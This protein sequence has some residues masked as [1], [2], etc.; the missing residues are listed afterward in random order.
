MVTLANRVKM[1][2]SGTPS[3]GTITLG[4]AETGY[5]TFAAGGVSDGDTVSYTVEDGD[6]WEI[7][8]GTYTSS[9]TTLSR[10]LVE[11]ST[12][13]LLDLSSS[14]IVFLTATSD[15]IQQPPSEGAFADGDKTKLDGIEASADVTDATNVSAAGALMKSGGTMTGKITLD[16]NPTAN[17]HSATKQYV[18]TIA[19]AGIHYHAP[20]RVEHPSNLTATYNNGSSGVGAT[21]TN[22]GT[23]AALVLDNVSMVLNDRVLVANQTD[24]TQNGVYTV[25]TVGDGSTAWVL[26]RSTD[27]DTAGPSDPDAFGKG[28]AFFIKEG[29]TNA[30]HLDV[31][32]TTGTIVFGTTN[33]VF[34]EVAETTVYSAGTGLTLT[35][36][37]FSADGANITNVDAVTLDGID[38]SQF[39]RSDAADTKTAGDLSFADNVKAIFGAGSDLEIYHDASNSYIVDGGT[40]D[41]KIQGANVRLENPSGVRYFQG[42]SGNTYLYNS[43]NIKLTTT[44]TGIDITGNVVVSG[45]VDGV[46]IAALNTSALTTS[47]TFG[48]DVSGTY[49]AIVVAND[50]HNH[51][52]NNLTSKTS[53]TGEYSTNNTLTAG[54]GSGGISLTVNDGYGNANITFN[55]KN[56]VPEQ[57]GQSGRITLNTDNTVSGNAQMDFE[58]GLG[59][60]STVINL[61]PVF[62]LFDDEV[63]AWQPLTVVG[64]ITASGTITSGGDT[65]LTTA[66][67]D[68]Q[69][70]HLKTNVD[71]SVT[72]GVANE[73]TVNFNLEEHND[74][75]TFSH[76]SGV[77]TVATAGWYRIVAN[78]VYQNGVASNRNTIRAYVKKNGT[79]IPSTATYD[80]DRGSSYG[81]FSN[82]K[83]NTMLY[84]AANDTIEIANYGQ[85]IDG[86][87]TI[88]S[89]ECEFMVSSET[90]QATSSNA[91]TVDGLHGSQFLRSDAA[92][93]TSSTISFT[94][95]IEVGNKIIH[96]GDTDTYFQFHSANQARIVAG[97]NEV[98]EW[99]AGYVLM[100]DGDDLYFGSGF[101]L[102]IFHDGTN[103]LIRNQ[104]HAAGDIY[105]QGEDTSGV[106]HNIAAFYSSNA[107]PYTGLYY[108]GTEVFTT[109]SGGV[110]VNGNI[111]AV[112]NIY[113]ADNIY[114]EGD[115][116]TRINLSTGSIGFITNSVSRS[117]VNDTRFQIDR[118]LLDTALCETYDN[119][120][121]ASTVYPDLDNGGAF[122]VTLGGNTTFSFGTHSPAL[123]TDVS[124]GFILEVTGNASSVYTITWPTSVDWA[125][126]TAPDAPGVGEKDIYVFWTRNAG[127]TWYGML[128][129]DAA[130]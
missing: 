104:N 101:D 19:A 77:V 30:G 116:G 54:R 82:N 126:G 97:G 42:S 94:G 109:V 34:S 90:V 26:T 91:D 117:S 115:T 89:A 44:S 121:W 105:I 4:T 22:A 125:G 73:F 48:G 40:G 27:T 103:S 120:S 13:S 17:L 93:S 84:L 128:A 28:D 67:Y 106:N 31:L 102:R 39:L 5:Q 85:N 124:T 18:D 50:S 69:V 113:L 55:H 61:P 1:N 47:T 130:A 76:T 57:N 3:T 32:T 83:I 59:T 100:S 52:F 112:D 45:T 79:E 41:L 46:D 110:N 74:T 11:S 72:Q 10:T 122:S 95:D 36:T 127:T 107:A 63:K 81:E 33:I 21:L 58:L 7:G 9:G 8:T 15:D 78:L 12:G 98:M 65:V 14:A 114:H 43:G 88:E 49:N 60:A 70:C 25:T 24:Q 23:N 86:S 37:E 119:L 66:D 38:S 71:A 80:Y 123:A 6:A 118:L 35:G 75:S 87:V 96:T 56:G 64:G 108:D 29:D 62:S 99:G 20:V 129:I 53:G 92:D 51:Q 2:V 111:N 68:V 16:G